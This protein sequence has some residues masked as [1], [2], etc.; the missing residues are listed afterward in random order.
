MGLSLIRTVFSYITKRTKKIQYNGYRRFEIILDLLSRQGG[1]IWA[2][3]AVT[4]LH[5]FSIFCARSQ[6]CKQEKKEKEVIL[7]PPP[8]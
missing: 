5:P 1:G 3:P 7:H 8:G 6:P 2:P 4:N